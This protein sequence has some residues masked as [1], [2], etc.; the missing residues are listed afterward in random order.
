[1]ARVCGSKTVGGVVQQ[2]FGYLTRRRKRKELENVQFREIASVVAPTPV[3]GPAAGTRGKR[4][5]PRKTLEIISYLLVSF[6]QSTHM[7]KVH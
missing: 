2:T 1:M 6:V 7:T 5:D 3:V 4:R